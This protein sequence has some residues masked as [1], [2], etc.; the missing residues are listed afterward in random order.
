MP[1]GAIRYA[2]SP[3]SNA[4]TAWP[5]AGGVCELE[6]GFRR[7]CSRPAEHGDHFHPWS[8]GGAT[9][10]QNFV[11]ACARCDRTKGGRACPPRADS[12]GWSAAVVSIFRPPTPCGW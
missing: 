10:L 12:G 3:G 1:G 7:R 4:A 11:A 5:R 9:S 8:R 6:G 2:G